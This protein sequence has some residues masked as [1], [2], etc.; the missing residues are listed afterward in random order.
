MGFTVGG[1]FGAMMGATA[2][3]MLGGSIGGNLGGNAQASQ[4]GGYPMGMM[5]GGYGMPNMGMPMMGNMGMMPGMMDPMMGMGGMNPMMGGM[6]NPMMGG[7]MGMPFMPGGGNPQQMMMMQMMMQMM[8]MM[9]MMMMMNGFPPG[10]MGGMPTM[11]P[12]GFMGV[13][14]GMPAMPPYGHSRPLPPFAMG[15]GQMNPGMNIPSYGPN[16][17]MGQVGGMLNAAAMKYGIPPDLLKAV[18]WQESGWKTNA[19]SFDGGHGKGV[20]QIDD[21][22]H[23]LARTGQVWDPATNIDYG[24]HYLRDLYNKTGNWQEALRR[25]N[26]GRDYPPR[27]MAHM[28]SKPWQRHGVA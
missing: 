10:M 22:F 21:R 14:G 15:A 11:D 1:P 12:R 8:Q 20:M 16:A 26:G 25:Y 23:Q 9:Q 18:A 24:A 19:S 17:N 6:N 13:P 27:I 3:M 5:G 7:Q 28:Q 2:G 4:Y